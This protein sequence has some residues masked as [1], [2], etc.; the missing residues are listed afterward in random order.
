MFLIEAFTVVAV[1][2]ESDLISTALTH[3]LE[4][5]RVCQRLA[6]ESNYVTCTRV[7]GSLSLIKVMDTAGDDNR[8]R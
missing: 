1:D 3:F 2:T 5:V 6:S 4:P 8:Y 7:N